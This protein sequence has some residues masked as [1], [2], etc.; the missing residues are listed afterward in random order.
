MVVAGLKGFGRLGE[1]IA[2]A[3]A[4]VALGQADAV[5]GDCD[6]LF[7]GLPIQPKLGAQADGRKTLAGITLDVDHPLDILYGI[8]QGNRD[9]TLHILSRR[10]GITNENRS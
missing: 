10:S 3:V 9:V 6:L 2:A 1:S 8:L 5:Q 4:P 7:E